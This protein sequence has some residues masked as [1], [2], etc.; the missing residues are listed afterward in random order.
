MFFFFQFFV[1]CKLKKGDINDARKKL[2]IEKKL[3]NKPLKMAKI[4]I[5][6]K[7]A[8]NRGLVDVIRFPGR[9]HICTC[10]I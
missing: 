4:A 1:F 3:Q 7:I 6:L 10:N 9:T 2:K 5:F 8:K